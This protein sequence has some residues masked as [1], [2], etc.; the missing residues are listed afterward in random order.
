MLLG[1]G[2][3]LDLGVQLL[4]GGELHLL[5]SAPCYCPPTSAGCFSRAVWGL[6]SWY[7]AGCSFMP[8]SV[9][10]TLPLG[11]SWELQACVSGVQGVGGE[12]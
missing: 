9:R 10:H 6:Q 4:C 1:W 7:R 2:P 8:C 11:C 5:C 3:A 12:T